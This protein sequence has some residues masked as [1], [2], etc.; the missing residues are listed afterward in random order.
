MSVRH[1]PAEPFIS[2]TQPES[3]TR[4]GTRDQRKP[5][6]IDLPGGRQPMTV[7]T[8]DGPV[9]IVYSGETY[10]FTELREQLAVPDA[11]TLDSTSI[12]STEC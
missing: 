9:V 2:I 8:P 11:S 5:A 3:S 10:T 12:S 7:D 4:A 1:A 6:I